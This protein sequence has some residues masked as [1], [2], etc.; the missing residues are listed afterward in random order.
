[1]NIGDLVRHRWETAYGVGLVVDEGIERGTWHVLWTV[2]KQ[3]CI[4]RFAL[5]II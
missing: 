1:M 3:T 2:G 5:E 4:F